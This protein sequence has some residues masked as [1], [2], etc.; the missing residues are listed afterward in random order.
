[1]SKRVKGDERSQ[2]GNS[3]R[4][5][6]KLR[7]DRKKRRENSEGYIEGREAKGRQYG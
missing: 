3:N 6:E 4:K 5:K 7:T 2:K 1:M